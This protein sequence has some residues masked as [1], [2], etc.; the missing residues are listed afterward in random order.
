MK[1]NLSAIIFDMDGV[2][3]DSEPVH[4]A[5]EFELHK[6]L[7]IKVP[8]SMFYSFVGLSL[9]KMWETLKNEFSLAQSVEELIRIDDVFRIEYFSRLDSMPV[10]TGIPELLEAVNGAG[11]PV[12]LASSSPRKIIDY[13]LEKSGL[14]KYFPLTISGQEVEH[15]K[16]APD[17]FLAAASLV[18]RKPSDCL[19][20]EDSRNGVLAAKAAGM[21]CLG[22]RSPNSGNQDLS[23]ADWITDRFDP[24]QILELTGR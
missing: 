7:G 9:Y 8:E 13:T 23:A 16:P 24:K 21:S 10:I 4:M 14:K 6:K 12:A 17:I 22:F 5:A 19:V 3:V 2:L 18:A 1:A 11:L 20:I 15:G